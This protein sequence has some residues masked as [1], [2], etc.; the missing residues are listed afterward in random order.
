MHK[1]D[2][3][4]L[5]RKK[6]YSYIYSDFSNTTKTKQ[7]H[8]MK[9]TLAT[10]I[11]LL[12][13]LPMAMAADNTKQKIK[14]IDVTINVPKP[15]MTVQ[16]GEELKLI[17]AKT[18]FG[19]LAATGVI[20]MQELE[21]NGN[22]DESDDEHPKFKPGYTYEATVRLMVNPE[23]KYTTDYLFKDG[24]YFLDA[25]HISITVNGK[26]GRVVTSPPYFPTIK[27]SFTMPGAISE[28]DMREQNKEQN[29]LRKVDLATTPALSTAE[30][31][32]L[33]VGKQA[34]DILIMNQE[35]K[36]EGGFT[37]DILSDKGS[38]FPGQ[39][40]QFITKLILDISDADCKDNLVDPFAYC[41]SDIKNGPHNLREVWLSNKVNVLEFVK[42]L[43]D[44]MTNSLFINYML[45]DLGFLS[46]RATLYIPESEAAKVREV[47]ASS[48]Y[49]PV[50]TVR[51]YS[52]DVYAA[53]KAGV[54]ATKPICTKHDYR[55]KIKAAD[56]IYKYENCQRGLQWF[57]S[58]QTCGKCE[59]NPKHTFNQ[60]IGLENLHPVVK[61]YHCFK[62]RLATDEAYVGKNA[63]GK[64][65]YWLSCIWCG[66]SS[67]YFECNPSAA[68]FKKTAAGETLEGVKRYMID[69]VKTRESEACNETVV[70]LGMFA[71]SD[72]ATAKMSAKAQDGV[73]HA[74]DEHLADG[75]DLGSDYTVG[76]TCRQ[77]STMAVNLVRQLTGKTVD[78]QSILAFLPGNNISMDKKASRQDMAAILYAALRCVENN[79]DYTYS[80]YDSRLSKYTDSQQLASWAK[81][82]MAFMEALELIAPQTSTTIAP[83]APC[84]IETALTVAGRCIYAHKGG[85]WQAVAYGEKPVLHENQEFISTS[86]KNCNSGITPEIATTPRSFS[87]SDRVWVTRYQPGIELFLPTVD[88]YSKQ[89]VYIRADWFRPIRKR[90]GKAVCKEYSF[91]NSPKGSSAGKQG[92]NKN[93]KK[94]KS[95]SGGLLSKGLKGLSGLL[96]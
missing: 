13:M 2:T 78:A 12:T 9:K 71:L 19:D 80:D 50:Y 18:P 51:T 73:N 42:A 38:R 45:F 43:N 14:S 4:L 7:N 91:N 8:I 29:E 54:S 41:L 32:A 40:Q 16:A 77:V 60:C 23:S 63:A 27:I 93:K 48:E 37:T 5:A 95:K 57:Y 72:K 39:Q 35:N 28:K 87:Y 59:Y 75:A 84:S 81:D 58:C 96:K 53:Q 15:G 17:S 49:Y 89:T 64:H 94:G 33:W 24:D 66:R 70:P 79:S 68:D 22:F 65:L 69:A 47:L 83:N 6:D 36:P 46:S 20:S 82:P 61:S 67:K 21:W 86:H 85:W 25:N 1:Q 74:M 55:K 10:I 90:A 44:G 62:A 26:N 34:K 3:V 76:V 88:P 31:D 30:A 52:G 11:L 92:G 56:R